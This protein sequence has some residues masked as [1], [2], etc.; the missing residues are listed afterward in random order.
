MQQEVGVRIKRFG[1]QSIRDSKFPAIDLVPAGAVVSV[2]TWQAAQPT[3][4]NNSD[5]LLL[6]GVSASCESRAGALEARMKRAK[7]SRSSS[8]SGSDGSFGSGAVL[9]SFVTSSGK[10]RVV[11]PISLR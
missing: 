8:P 11:I 6:T 4:S 9:H 7:W 10:S 1:S 2:R 5:P 3:L